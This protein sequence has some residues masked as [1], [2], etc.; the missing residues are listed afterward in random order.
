MT[1]NGDYF[2][3]I[4]PGKTSGIVNIKYDYA[5]GSAGREMKYPSSS[6]STSGDDTYT[7]NIK[8]TLPK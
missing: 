8:V 4:P 7:Y 6:I 1:G 2:I 3:T 5:F